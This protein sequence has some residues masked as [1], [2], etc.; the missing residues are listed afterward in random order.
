ML[1][2]DANGRPWALGARRNGEL[3]VEVPGVAAFH[4]EAGSSTLR[5]VAT[6]SV[7]TDAVLDAYFG[8]ALPLAAQAACGLE[9]LH[10]SAVL[11][12]SLRHV[13]AFCGPSEAG[14]STIAFGLTARGYHQ[15]ADDAVAF[16]LRPPRSV[17]TVGLPF[18][19]K[20]R[21]SSAAYFRAS[22][23]GS[24]VPTGATVVNDF[25]WRPAFLRG[26]VVLEPGPLAGASRRRIQLESLAPGPALR[27][28]L[29]HAYKYRFEPRSQERRRQTL[30]AYLALVASVPVVRALFPRVL[31]CFEDLLDE[32]ERWAVA[33]A[34]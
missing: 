32:L 1:V 26:I 8:T 2:H 21:E 24:C 6:G 31:G 10:G 14:K 29:S 25:A 23:A 34:V 18:T 11:D 15:W 30:D 13:V 7:E 4:L 5:A 33:E 16:C 17:E 12:P 27:A 9:V 20:L 22:A 3:W 28:V 19:P